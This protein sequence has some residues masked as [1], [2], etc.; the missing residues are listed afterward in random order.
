MEGLKKGGTGRKE[1]LEE[2]EKLRMPTREASLPTS[3]AGI[4]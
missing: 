3:L 2:R 1:T 4:R